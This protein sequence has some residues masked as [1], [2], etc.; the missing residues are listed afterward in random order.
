[1]NR[2]LTVAEREKLLRM[3]RAAR[4]ERSWA[5]LAPIERVDR[6]GRIALSSAQQRLW[7][8]EQLGGM[9]STYNVRRRL[10]L[11]GELDRAALRRALDR[12][13]A[14]HEAL[15]TTFV[16]VDGEPEQRIASAE[17]SAFQLVEHDLGG[18]ADAG[19]ELGRLVQEEGDAPFDLGRGPLIRGRLIRL[20]E[21]D[22]VL[23]LTMHHIVSDAWS[24]GVLLDELG[25][26]YGAFLGGEADPLPP[27]P[28][29]YADY[30]AWQRRWMDGEVLARQADYWKATL[31]GAPRLLELPADHARPER[32]DHAGAAVRVELDEELAAALRALGQRHGTTLFMTLLAGWA[33]TLG[34]LSGQ[35]DVVVG[36]PTANR[37]R[38]EIEGLIGFFV[39]TLPLRV[40]LAGSPT[41][42]ELLARVRERVVEAQQRQ[43]I[44][45][46]QVVELVQP[47]R[48]LAHSPVF[49]A[50]FAWQNVPRS[51]LELPGLE[52]APVQGP[53]QSTVKFD[54]DLTLGE[55]GGR[56]VGTVEYA[57]SLFERDT[58]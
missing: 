25:A 20:G 13:V 36:T 10:R 27:L 9:G 57:T 37:E 52:L 55:I 51:S 23:L 4:L 14:R 16:A 54:L 17:A 48:S 31:A 7:F 33:A 11:R 34:R 39:N 42:A 21:R 15:R 5:A 45:F 53:A 50:M 2:T 28:V 58:T 44:P 35:D 47:S 30:A 29:Q 49:Q 24:T 38:P 12:I 6:G 43:D 19:A 26:L 46:E 3:A 18:H 56:I 32:Q 22:H 8:L 1:M 40:D 41:V